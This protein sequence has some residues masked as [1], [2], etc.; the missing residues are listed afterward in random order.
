MPNYPLPDRSAL[1]GL[2]L[3]AGKLTLNASHMR[4]H[5]VLITRSMRLNT[6][7]PPKFRMKM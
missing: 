1:T 4:I 3:L 7:F 2:S 6:D 5:L